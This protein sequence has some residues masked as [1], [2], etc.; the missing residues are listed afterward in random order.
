MKESKL[1][2][3]LLLSFVLTAFLM[4]AAFAYRK[5][6]KHVIYEGNA[7][8]LLAAYAQTNQTFTVFTNRNWSVLADWEASL[9]DISLSED[10]ES[11][12]QEFA[13]RKNNWQYSDFYM[14]NEDC[15]FLT[16][17][18]RRG[19]AD[20]IENVFRKMYEFGGN[21][22]SAYT[23]S[24]GIRKIVFAKPLKESFTL[25]S[26]TYTGVAVSYDA[27]VVD[28]MLSK[29]VYS[30][31]SSCYLVN[32][33]G[34][35][36]LS[37]KPRVPDEE[38]PENLFSYLE[39]QVR[40]VEGNRE[41]VQQSVENLQKGYAEFQ[42]KNGSYYL[43]YQPVGLN[44]WTIVGV[45]VSSVVD[46]CSEKIMNLTML[47]FTGLSVCVAFLAIRL[48]TLHASFE[49]EKQKTIHAALESLANT[50]GL[51]G[52]FNER[53]FSSI[54][55]EKESGKLPFVLYYLDLDRFKPVNDSYG[56]DM[57]DKL[58]KEV[59][60]RLRQCIREQDY[61]FRIGGDEFSL[62]I[63]SEMT[64]EACAELKER[65]IGTILLPYEIDGQTLQL[66]V[67]CGYGRY[68]QESETVSRLRILA[69]QKMYAEKEK[70][71]SASSD[72]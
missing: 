28:A 45:V 10:P 48:I 4:A 46:A 18:S 34:D 70:N 7:E 2:N 11:R 19:T 66:G 42:T 12:W 65:I 69:D 23:A 15:D 49:L 26:I 20:S 33:H 31:A 61:A 1:K 24:S 27:A 41:I 25:G 63:S 39:N 57:G 53:C 52:L 38:T 58:L 54:L 44:D 62:I 43:L 5:Y 71:H 36:V 22:V 64:E 72:L 40:F 9:Q 56:H 13:R 21:F 29:D 8:Q 6:I 30:D 50:D 59:A 16:A 51:T 35:V 32:A 68:P 55:H 67:S 3:Y 17:N 47:V 60:E 14:F 37:L